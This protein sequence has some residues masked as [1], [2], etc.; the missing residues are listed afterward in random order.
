MEE[1]A[2]E[3]IF[4][5]L[6]QLQPFRAALYLPSARDV[7]LLKVRRGESQPGGGEDIHSGGGGVDLGGNSSLQ[8]QGDAR[9]RSPSPPRIGGGFA[10]YPEGYV[11]PPR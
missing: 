7:S 2:D 11:S 8:H 1:K 10:Y 6:A 4:D 5:E 3:R 9:S